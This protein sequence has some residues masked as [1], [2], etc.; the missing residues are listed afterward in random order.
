METM[1]IPEYKDFL[2][3]K[4]SGKAARSRSVGG[5][6]ADI[7]FFVRSRW[8]ANYVRILR[9]LNQRFEYEKE[10]FRFPVERGTMTYLPDFYLP[11]KDQFV[12]LKG[13]LDAKSKTQ[14]SRF[15]QYHPDKAKRMRVV[16]RKLFA[17][18]GSLTPDAAALV[19]MGYD[20]EQL[21]SYDQWVLQFSGVIEN[22]ER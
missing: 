18:R 1:T 4:P 20:I 15:M 9:F 7:G 11:D 14:L 5:R 21:L 6:R 22:W 19:K 16:I 2:A 8:E 12:E 3:S 13:Y 17:G 10:E